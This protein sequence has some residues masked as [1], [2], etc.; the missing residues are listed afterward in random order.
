MTEN[1]ETLKIITNLVRMAREAAERGEFDK[2]AEYFDEAT[3][4]AKTLGVKTDDH[5]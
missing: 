5:A 3:N 4:I 2:C 1:L